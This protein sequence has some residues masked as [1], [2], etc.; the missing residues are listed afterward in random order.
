MDDSAAAAA[1]MIALASLKPGESAARTLCGSALGACV[2]VCVCGMLVE[3]I[4]EA[5]KAERNRVSITD[6]SGR[7]YCCPKPCKRLSNRESRGT[8]SFLVS[9]ECTLVYRLT[10][11]EFELSSGS[12]CSGFDRWMM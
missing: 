10:V 2:C 4:D 8:L 5:C 1:P 12:R 3:R 11:G 9:S 7:T 6:V